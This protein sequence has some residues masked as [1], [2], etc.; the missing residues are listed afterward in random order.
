MV[1]GGQFIGVGQEPLIVI[2]AEGLHLMTEPEQVDRAAWD[3]IDARDDPDPHSRLAGL[4]DEALEEP[5]DTIKDC[6]FENC[7]ARIK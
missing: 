6:T 7:T 2:I 1:H 5:V 4:R 3:E